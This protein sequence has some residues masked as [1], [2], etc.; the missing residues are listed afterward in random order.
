MKI[1]ECNR[2]RNLKINDMDYPITQLWIR[3]DNDN[4]VVATDLQHALMFE[5]FK[6]FKE[7]KRLDDN[8]VELMLEVLNYDKTVLIIL[9]ANI[10][11]FHSPRI[12]PGRHTG[13]TGKPLEDYEL[14]NLK[15][16]EV[17]AEDENYASQ[18]KGQIMLEQL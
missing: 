17:I 6:V 11:P 3:R 12:V 14:N 18:I 7:G 13:I 4:W 1:V 5:M 2:N 8:F 16:K 15:I 9:S 10:H